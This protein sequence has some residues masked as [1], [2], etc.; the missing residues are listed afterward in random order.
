MAKRIVHQLIDDLDGTLLQDGEGETQRFGIDGRTYEIDLSTANAGA[1]RD[2]LKPY[3]DAGRRSA[4]QSAPRPRG[5]S[6]KSST[7]S[8][9]VREWATSQGLDVPTRGRVPN[10]VLEAYRGAH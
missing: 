5:R 2:A 9:N 6:K 4:G 7:Q 8:G 1:L 10:A 3:I